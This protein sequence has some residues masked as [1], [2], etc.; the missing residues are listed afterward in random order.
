MIQ[1]L[2]LIVLTFLIRFVN[3]KTVIVLIRKINVILRTMKQLL[4]FV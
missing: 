2:R 4:S 3:T 1:L